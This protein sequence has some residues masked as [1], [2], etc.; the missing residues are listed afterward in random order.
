M[1][2]VSYANPDVLE[3]YRV[4]P[5]NFMA[6]AHA[7]AAAVAEHNVVQQQ[8]GLLEPLL[9]PGV[10]VLDVGCGTG[11]LAQTLAY[12]YKAVVTGIDFNPVAIA[13]AQETAAVARLTATF[14]AADLFEYRPPQPFA[15]VTSLGVLSHQ[16]LPRRR[17][18][19]RRDVP[20]SRRYVLSGPVPRLWPQAVSGCLC[21]TETGGRF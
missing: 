20:G 1:N 21:R 6:S 14:V 16:Q 7:Q 11:W 13:R 18:A 5:F 8:Y 9:T 4:M 12:H 17:Q 15:I 19:V 3:F 10:R 2:A